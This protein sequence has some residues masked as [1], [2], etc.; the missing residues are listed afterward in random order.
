M[1][2]KFQL[3]QDSGQELLAVPL[4]ASIL[5]P[6]A[7]TLSPAAPARMPGPPYPR[8]LDQFLVTAPRS[9][10]A[11]S[12]CA[13]LL[14]H[15]AIGQVVVHVPLGFGWKN[16]SVL[17]RAAAHARLERSSSSSWLVLAGTSWLGIM[18]LKM[19]QGFSIPEDDLISKPT[20][21]YWLY[22]WI[23]RIFTFIL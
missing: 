20:Y 10:R 6:F 7:L 2:N 11:A 9:N 5:S 14:P 18:A 23:I 17:A 3:S 15:H 21:I 12:R 13:G 4:L 22:D 8:V 1:C 16:D 19:K